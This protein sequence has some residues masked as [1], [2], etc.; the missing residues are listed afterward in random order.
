M[1]NFTASTTAQRLI[2][3]D[4]LRKTL[5]IENTDS[6]ITVYIAY[7]AAGTL[8]STNFDKRL[9]ANGNV[10]FDSIS[11]PGVLTKEFWVVAA[12]GNPVVAYIEGR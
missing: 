11:D 9:L 10:S 12:L 4:P 1:P 8:S 7:S 3:A 2:G 5:F 6:T